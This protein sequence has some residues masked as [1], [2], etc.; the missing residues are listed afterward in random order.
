MFEDGLDVLTKHALHEALAT[1]KQFL[2]ESNVS[3]MGRQQQSH[4]R[5]VLDHGQWERCKGGGEGITG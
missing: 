1:R 5:E 4:I 2:Q 3:P